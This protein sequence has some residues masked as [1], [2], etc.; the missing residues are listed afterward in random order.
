MSAAELDGRLVGYIIVCGFAGLLAL[1][2][3]Q[4]MQR[5]VVARL[6]QVPTGMRQNILAK[7]LL[8]TLLGIFALWLALQPALWSGAF[9]PDASGFVLFDPHGKADN[10]PFLNLLRFFLFQGLAEEL[11][12]RGF[13]MS[14][15]VTGVF[16]AAM[17]YMRPADAGELWAR[18]CWIGS[19]LVVNLLVS[20]TFAIW[21]SGNPEV[22][23]LAIVNIG[24]A[25]MVLGQLFLN[26]ASVGGAAALH[27]VWNLG[28]AVMG[29]PVSGILVCQPLLGGINGA[30]LKLISGGPFGPEGS[31]GTSAALLMV[32]AYLLWTAM[33]G[34]RD[35]GMQDEDAEQV[36]LATTG[37]S[38]AD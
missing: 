31:L 6:E 26:Q 15:L 32:F 35:A 21:H 24:L 18:T 14:M 28:Q 8:G 33:P 16:A 38:D 2:A 22:D 11:V 37:A 1:L 23:T 5:F 10:V 27:I 3:W 19:G 9:R 7:L 12:Y 36:N 20:A 30:G 25:G 17:R 29:L 13:A 4:L 34:S